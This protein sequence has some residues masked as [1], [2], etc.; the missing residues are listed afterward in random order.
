MSTMQHV[1]LFGY[2]RTTRSIAKRFGPMSFYDDHVHKPFVDDQGNRVLRSDMFDPHRS[3]L[4]IPSPGIPPTHPLITQARHLTS[5]YDL[6]LSPDAAA[7]FALRPAPY[8]VWITGTNGKTTTTQMTAHLLAD[9]GAIAGGNIGVPLADL[10]PNASIWVLETSSF[11]LHYTRQAAPKLYIVLPITPDHIA[12]HGNE[13]AY[14]ADKLSAL[15]RM[16]EGD[17]AIVPRRFANTLATKA[18]V[19]PYDTAE[20][21]AKH[22]GFDTAR[23]RFS[24]AFLLD[25]LLAM[26]VDNILFDRTDYDRIDAFTLDPHRQER[27]YD[28]RGRLWINDTKATNIDAT[29]A[30]LRTFGDK[31]V[32]LILGGDDKGVELSPLF[33]ALADYSVTVYAVGRNAGRLVGLAQQYRIPVYNA[34]TVEHAV[35]LIDQDL[36]GESVALLSP[37]AASLDQFDSYAHRGEVFKRSVADLS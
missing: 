5:E 16:C 11:T 8:Q 7:P 22:F 1:S 33:D 4:E 9:K 13:A 31:P 17:V 19:I 36:D 37:A 32:H 26:A 2:G 10:D 34:E 27:F 25:A 28:K 6:F 23:I 12:W 21:L 18:F 29:V 30:A 3:D 24:G 14:V 35:Q 20:D 15:S